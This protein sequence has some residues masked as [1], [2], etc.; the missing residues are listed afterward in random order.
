M[1][2]EE[3]WKDVEGYEGLYQ[4]SNFGRVKSLP[5]PKAKNGIM[6]TG[7][8]TRGYA[9]VSLYKNSAKK[10]VKVHRLVAA[11]FFEKVAGKEAINHIDGVKTNNHIDNLEW[12]T[13]SENRIHALM[14]GLAIGKAY[15]NKPVHQF[16]KEG[17]FIAEHE[18]IRGAARA[19]G[20]GDTTLGNCLKGNRKTCGGF[21]WKYAESEDKNG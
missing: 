13:N 4:V 15:N 9:R 21:V 12:V 14:T 19:I 10:T 20:R 8:D 7:A 16:T 18:S 6:I 5:R 17:Q 11:A 3:I 1:T 2:V